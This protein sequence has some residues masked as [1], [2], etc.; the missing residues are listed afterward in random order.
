[1]AKTA[2]IHARM[3]EKIK[4]EAIKVFDNLG[5]STADAITLFFKQVALK[6]GIPFELTADKLTQTNL[7][8]VSHF[9]RSNV[10]N[11][12]K[13]LPESVDE[14]W[15][16]GSAATPYCKPTSDLDVCVIGETISH[17]E[18]KAIF[19]APKCAMDLLNTTHKEFE[20]KRVY[21]GDIF[22]EVYNKGL[23]IYKKGRGLVNGKI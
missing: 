6:N 10:E 5:M 3:D 16:F 22:Y 23:L 8:K 12:L 17:D 1:M 13:M 9:R 14:L 7:D 11:I 19:A 21:D 15:V 4:E 20:E 18:L 2:T